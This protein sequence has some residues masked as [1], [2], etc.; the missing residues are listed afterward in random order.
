[1]LGRVIGAVYG[2]PLA[3]FYVR[4]RIP[5]EL[6][7]RFAILLGLGATQVSWIRSRSLCSC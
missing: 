1:M 2:L 3:Y 4:N 7:N 6:K 5:I